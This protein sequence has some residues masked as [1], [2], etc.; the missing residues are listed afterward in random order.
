M[1][2]LGGKVINYKKIRM[3]DV[4]NMR[5][6]HQRSVGDIETNANSIDLG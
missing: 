2:S 1:T 5:R 3:G 6:S 4:L